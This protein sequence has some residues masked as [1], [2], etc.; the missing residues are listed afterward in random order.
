MC[1][2]ANHLLAP[3]WT[4]CLFCRTIIWEGRWTNISQ[5][6]LPRGREEVKLSTGSYLSLVRVLPHACQF[7]CISRL[8]TSSATEKPCGKQP[9]SCGTRRRLATL[10]PWEGR[11]WVELGEAHAV[12]YLGNVQSKTS[13]LYGDAI[14]CIVFKHTHRLRELH[15]V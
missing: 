11:S 7:P 8:H 3:S 4:D 2:P 15:G 9:E 5:N 1:Y 6:S 13:G 10:C 14:I 12:C